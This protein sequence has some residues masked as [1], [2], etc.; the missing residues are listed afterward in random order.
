VHKQ[1]QWCVQMNWDTATAFDMSDKKQFP[2][3]PGG[4]S[5]I[6]DIL[7][8]MNLSPDRML[9]MIPMNMHLHIN[10][11]HSWDGLLVRH[12]ACPLQLC[13]FYNTDTCFHFG[14]LCMM[15]SPKS[16]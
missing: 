2:Q 3:V 10:T 13:P 7:E 5:A 9:T 8:D 6:R 16:L 11:E 4:G 15:I 1:Q 14:S 12:T